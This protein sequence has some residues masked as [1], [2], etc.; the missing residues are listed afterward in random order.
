MCGL[1][2]PPGIHLHPQL[3]LLPPKTKVIT[4][5]GRGEVRSGVGPETFTSFFKFLFKGQY[6]QGM[7]SV[8]LKSRLPQHS[9]P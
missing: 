1:C 4:S 3:S 5:A 6:F 8:M 9:D 7:H 2:F